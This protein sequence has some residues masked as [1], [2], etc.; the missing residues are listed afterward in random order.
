MTLANRPEGP[1]AGERKIAGMLHGEGLTAQR[2][3]EITTDRAGKC[4][5]PAKVSA[6]LRELE[7]GA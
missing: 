3:A 2:A 6:A 1:S 4:W 7:A 5:L